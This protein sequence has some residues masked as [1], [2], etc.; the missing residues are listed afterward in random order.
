MKEGTNEKS[1][2]ITELKILILKVLEF[3]NC[4][5]LNLKLKYFLDQNTSN[6]QS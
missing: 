3:T 1:R 6:L 5:K 2:K 4:T